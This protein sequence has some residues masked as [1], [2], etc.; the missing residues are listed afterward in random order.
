MSDDVHHINAP[1][2]R[3]YVAGIFEGHG[4]PAD[5]AAIVANNLVDADLRGVD[6]HGVNLV[7]LYCKR[8]DDGH[9]AKSAE[10]Q[11]VRDDDTTALLDGGLGLGQ[12]AGMQALDL[13][14]TKAK[15]HGVAAVGV[16]ESTHLGALAYYTLRAAEQGCIAIAVQNGPPIVPPFG[17]LTGVF[18][19]NPFSYAVPAGKE[20][21]IVLDM[22]TTAVAGNR[23]ILYRKKNEPIPDWWAT[24]ADGNKTT[25][26]HVAS[27]DHLQWFGG[28]KGYGMAMMVE[29]LS[30]CLLSASFGHTELTAGIAHG[31][32]RVGKGY[33]FI[34]I[35]IARFTPLETFTGYVDTLIT[36]IRSGERAVGVDRLYVPGEIEHLRKVERLQTGLP[37][38][39]A[40]V[41]ELES[42]GLPLGLGPLA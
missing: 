6:S 4:V 31:K 1:D 41:A 30:G 15:A 2:L 42:L 34:V 12:I 22:A 20:Y 33:L 28:Y 14:V 13:A 39:A 18:S 25:D 3:G 7:A 37:L 23:I 17:G 36:D 8:L 10:V 29:L 11:T 35:D 16:R 27:L 24:D 38:D 5:H 19:T 26:P 9:M 21:P 40:L 32:A